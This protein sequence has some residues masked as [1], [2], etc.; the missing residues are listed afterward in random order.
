MRF[1]GLC[2]NRRIDEDFAAELE[3]HVAMATEDGM[4]AG[5]S[6]AE[7]RRQA[8]I[9][10]GGVEQTRQA[11][12]ERRGL[13]WLESLARDFRYGFR[14]LNKHRGATMA[15]VLSVGLGIGANATIFSL[16]SRF[17]LRPAPVGD[18]STLQALS[19]GHDGGACCDEF[20]LPIYQDVR[21]QSQSFSGVAAYYAILP[22]SIGGSG[23]PERVW[24]QAV[25]PNFFDVT[26]V[27]TVLGHGFLSSDDR[28]P[29]V[30][31]G[32]GL[33]RRRFNADSDIVGKSVLLSGRTFTVVGVAQPEFHS[34]DQLLYAEFWVPLG[35]ANLLA[36][37]LTNQNSRDF[38]WL[39]AIGRLK[40]GVTPAQA[41][42]ELHTVA[43]RLA[44]SYP[45][46]DKDNTF[47]VER[48]GTL[49]EKE[50]G[51]VLLFLSA[52]SVVVLLVLAI[53]CANVANLL[54][55]LAAGRQRDMAVRLA[56]GATRGRLR[57][58]L[59]IESVLLGLGG[60]ALGAALSI[61]ATRA[62]AAFHLPT[63]VPLDIG[64]S[65]DWRVVLYT[66]GLSVL[67][68][69]LLGMVPAWAA[70]RPLLASALRGEDALV[71]P[72]RRLSLRN[73]LAISQIAM[74]LVL[75]SLTGLFLRSLQSA[76]TIDIGFRSEHLLVMSVDPRLHGY[77]A[78]R[79]VDFLSQLREQVAALPGVASAVCTDY[80]PLSVGGRTDGFLVDG[81]KNS[82]TRPISTDLYMA[83]PG[84]LETMGI[85]LIAG[86]DFG[87][88]S[89]HGPKVAIVNRAFAERAFGHENPLGRQVSSGPATYEI[90]GV[91]S[92]TKSRTLGEGSRPVLY[93]SLLQSVAA[94]PSFLGYT[95]VVRTVGSPEALMESVRRRIHLLDPNMAIFNDATMEE[96]VRS[97]YFLPRLAAMLFGIFGA[98]GLVLSSVGLYGVMGYSVS[99]RTRE[100]GIR[101]ALGAQPGAVER[102]VLRQGFVLALIALALGWPAAWLLA[103]LA[104]SFLYGI[105]PHDAITFVLAPLLLAFIALVAS[106]IPAR[107]AASVDPMQALRAE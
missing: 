31:L 12:R 53:A 89:T 36:P 16:V 50:R 3:A 41:K 22:A 43:Q 49:P 90:V 95:L 63:P 75:L 96:H 84:F 74:S 46:T 104:Q 56:L 92:N 40:P 68:G 14:T 98:I 20:S 69:V 23:E 15:A 13:P 91:V 54:F 71:R 67:S 59:V 81:D 77:S 28:L 10:L 76:A 94:D 97:A 57:R 33:W 103:K 72:G 55:A 83:T 11:Y 21:D 80:V 86:N 30:V 107:R 99:R 102:L 25:T 85:P 39:M 48:A 17:V 100:I 88:E 73:L 60:G 4:R 38:H 32:A 42:T 62:L 78:G 8:L 61:W 29:E 6:V 79:T 26:Q 64:V 82:A 66:F 2:W 18:P 105:R 52:L 44:Q 24:G 37:G 101:I 35:N 58:Q 106:W 70:S 27:R 93:R 9:E 45:A 5:L 51:G 1:R 87:K 34:V 65:V 19:I 47:V 7:A